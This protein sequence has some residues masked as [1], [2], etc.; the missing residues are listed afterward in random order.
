MSSRHNKLRARLLAHTLVEQRAFYGGSGK[1]LLR[2]GEAGAFYQTCKKEREHS[3]FR[4][5]TRPL[6]PS[7]GAWQGGGLSGL[8][9]LSGLFGFSG[10]FVSLNKRNQRNQTN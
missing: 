2:P 4:E 10:F 5:I 1:S 3:E 6:Q 9:R 8:S 7:R